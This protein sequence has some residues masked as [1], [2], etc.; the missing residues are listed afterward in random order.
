MKSKHLFEELS[1][2]FGRSYSNWLNGCHFGF[3]VEHITYQLSLQTFAGFVL[4]LLLLALME[5]FTL[6]SASVYGVPYSRCCVATGKSP[7]CLAYEVIDFWLSDDICTQFLGILS[8]WILAQEYTE[9]TRC[10]TV[11]PSYW[12]GEME[13][14]AQRM[15]SASVMDVCSETSPLVVGQQ[16][17]GYHSTDT[18]ALEFFESDPR[19]LVAGISIHA[20][21]KV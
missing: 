2:F 18:G 14:K 3:L 11:Q 15:Q 8:V 19:G 5:V 6:V 16:V 17:T 12:C 4:L 10:F 13:P 9:L 1:K 21:R 7:R 20:L